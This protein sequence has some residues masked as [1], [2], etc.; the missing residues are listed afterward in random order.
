MKGLEIIFFCLMMRLLTIAFSVM[1]R[2]VLE[3]WDC[4]VY[5]DY[6]NFP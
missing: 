5:I 6:S 2:R 1:R 4:L 3:M